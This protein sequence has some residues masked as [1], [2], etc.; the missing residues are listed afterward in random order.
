MT[1]HWLSEKGARS[2]RADGALE[3]GVAEHHCQVPQCLPEL[4]AAPL[5]REW[6]CLAA[7]TPGLAAAGA[8][9]QTPWGAAQAPQVL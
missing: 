1:L 4:G 7:R 9:Q 2:D 5:L 6:T 3:A 8:L